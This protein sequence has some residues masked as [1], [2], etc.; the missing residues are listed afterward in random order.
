M[1]RGG[2][3][4]PTSTGNTH[5]LTDLTDDLQGSKPVTR[6]RFSTNS[7][8]VERTPVKAFRARFATSPSRSGAWLV[9]LGGPE[10]PRD[11]VLHSRLS[12]LFASSVVAQPRSALVTP[13]P[14]GPREDVVGLSAF[15]AG[16]FV[17]DLAV[18]PLDG[19]GSREIH[20]GHRAPGGSW[21][22]VAGDMLYGERDY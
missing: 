22:S 11:R 20:T 15:P 14:L 12:A 5:N 9:R 7:N 3:P 18:L 10:A 19:S 21:A 2:H 13:T 1:R 8:P 17:P 16:T 6:Q 4:R